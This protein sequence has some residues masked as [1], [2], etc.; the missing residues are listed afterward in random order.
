MPAVT[1]ATGHYRNG[2]LLAPLTAKIV[3]DAVLDGTIDAACAVTTP[4]RW[5]TKESA[6]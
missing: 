3:A 2:V 4:D 5:N 1:V 6:S